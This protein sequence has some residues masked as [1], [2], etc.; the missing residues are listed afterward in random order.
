MLSPILSINTPKEMYLY[1]YDAHEGTKYSS[2]R[3]RY[4][5]C[6]FYGNTFWFGRSGAKHPLEEHTLETF[7]V[8]DQGTS[9]CIIINEQ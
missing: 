2:H 8:G 5:V 3:Q 1:I 4:N 6:I 9:F 7:A